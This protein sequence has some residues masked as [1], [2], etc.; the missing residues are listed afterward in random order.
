MV[1]LTLLLMGIIAVADPL[2][3]R[4]VYGKHPGFFEQVGA[5]PFQFWLLMNSSLYILLTSAIKYDMAWLFM[6]NQWKYWQLWNITKKK[7]AIYSLE[8]LKK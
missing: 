5:N 7:Y 8:K 6:L 4:F 1:Q 3:V 2:F